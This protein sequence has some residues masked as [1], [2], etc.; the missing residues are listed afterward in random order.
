ML[1]LLI[2]GKPGAGKGTQAQKLIKHYNLTHIS[3]GD[4]YRNEIKKGSKIGIEANKYISNGDLV[5]D[6]MTND[7]VKE[8]LS[9]RNYPNGFLLDGFPRTKAQAKALDHMLENL[10]IKLTAVINVEV[11]DETIAKRMAGRR[12]CS[13]CG[14]TYHIEFHPPKTPGIC[15]VCNHKLI[16]R[17]DDMEQ[18]VRRR[19]AIYNRETKPLLHFYDKRHNLMH[20]DGNRPTDVVFDDI[21]NR[22]GDKEW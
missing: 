11:M 10:N 8:V 14:A 4:I 16:Q 2:M 20:I 7:I 22:L 18:S 3:T 17:V 19:L 15:D 12:V 5:P 9:E 6:G 1:N 13:N 21:V